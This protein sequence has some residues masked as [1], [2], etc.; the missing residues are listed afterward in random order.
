[1][2]FWFVDASIYYTLIIKTFPKA[3]WCGICFTLSIVRVFLVT[4]VWQC[5]TPSFWLTRRNLLPHMVSA[6]VFLSFSFFPIFFNVLK[7]K[8]IKLGNIQLTNWVSNVY[9]DQ[10]WSFYIFWLKLWLVA[11]PEMLD[12]LIILELGV[13]IHILIERIISTHPIQGLHFFVVGQE[14]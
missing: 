2:I 1:M 10:S 8:K 13:I 12:G 11:P 3:L 14:G 5:G 9:T 6:S 4:S 7:M